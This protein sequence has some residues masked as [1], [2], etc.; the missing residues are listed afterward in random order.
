MATNAISP[1][2]AILMDLKKPK[3]EKIRSEV[4]IL[5]FFFNNTHY[6]E[7]STIS[8]AISNKMHKETLFLIFLNSQK[9]VEFRFS[10]I[11]V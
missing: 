4:T 11:Y 8:F 10:F 3:R 7:L 5:R 9:V 1:I 6:F 2:N